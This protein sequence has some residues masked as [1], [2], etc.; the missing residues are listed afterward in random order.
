MVL[1]VCENYGSDEIGLS[2]VEVLS[3][4]LDKFSLLRIE[5]D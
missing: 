2:A 4:A 1:V 3:L 5:S